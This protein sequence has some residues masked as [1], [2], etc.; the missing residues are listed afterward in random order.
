M[1]AQK[2]NFGRKSSMYMRSN[3]LHFITLKQKSKPNVNYYEE[4]NL[5]QTKPTGEERCIIT[6]G[7]E[8]PLACVVSYP[9]GIQD[10]KDT[11]YGHEVYPTYP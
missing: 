2:K 9:E 5:L 10:I 6:L 1:T 7:H 4:E 8:N 3:D 11:N